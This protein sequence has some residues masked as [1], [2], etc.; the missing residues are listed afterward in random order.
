MNAENKQHRKILE[1]VARRAM[2]ERGLW[3]EFS[4]EVMAEIDRI[5]SP[6]EAKSERV[7]DQRHLLWS[8]IDNEDSLD[9]DQLTAAEALPQ[10]RMK[11]LVGIA[12]VDALVDKQTAMDRHAQHNTQTVYTPAR[13]FSMLP[14]KLSTDF[15]SLNVNE[16]RLVVVVEMVVNPDGT[17]E[18]EDVYQAVAH[19][20]ARLSYNN[21]A[22]WLD[23]FGEMPSG[24]AVVKDLAENLR[25]Q[26][27]VARRLKKLR[28]SQGAL[29]FETIE[30]RPVFDGDQVKSMKIEQKNVAKEMIQD[31]MIAANGITARFLAAAGYP[32]IRRVVEQ[33]KRWDRIV[34]LARQE[35]FKLPDEPDALA[36]D[37][38]LTKKKA[39]DPQQFPDL[40]LA[41]IKLM[42]SGEYKAE[43]ADDTNP[44]HFGLAVE[45]YAHSTAPNRRYTDLITHRLLK[46]VFEGKASAYSLDELSKLAAHCTAQ[47]NEVNKVERLTKKSAAALLYRNR[48]GEQFEAIVT[49]ASSKGTWVRLCRYPL[50]GK[51]V[52][53][54]N[55]IDVGDRVQV[56]LIGTNVE[57]GFIDFK[58][59]HS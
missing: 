3:P 51:L 13:I 30:G 38:F 49:G 8:S 11:L 43:P 31:F 14:E 35:N 18:H 36:L 19:N 28:Q 10:D 21:V 55:G 27:Q 7:R 26:E 32:S 29:S 46:S 1:E 15:T 12:D 24:I 16:D 56:E 44:D 34:E 33:P 40:S 2:E 52:R 17:L 57:K 5:P 9:L 59:I 53:G 39:E 54:A 58:L 20:H 25:M 41:V 48:T 22:A 47:E 23:G 4:N 45:D 37:K 42:G 50:E 6:A